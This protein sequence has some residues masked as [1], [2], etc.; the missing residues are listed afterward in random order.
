[1]KIICLAVLSCFCIIFKFS[2]DTA[3]AS[4][5]HIYYLKYRLSFI[6]NMFQLKEDIEA[7]T[8]DVKSV[9]FLSV[10]KEYYMASCSRDGFVKLW[11]LH[12]A[13]QAVLLSQHDEHGCFVNSV[14]LRSHAD[15]G[16]DSIIVSSGG[17][18]GIIYQWDNLSHKLC[19]TL[20]GHTGNVCYLENL[21]GSVQLASCSWDKTARIWR[22]LENVQ[23]IEG[24]NEAIWCCCQVSENSFLTGIQATGIKFLSLITD[25]T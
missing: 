21:Y 18:D 7:H 1:M 4:I 11:K 17:T 2:D 16:L 14:S 13:S 6:I 12:A 20:I 23:T 9:K 24:H 3:E 8:S 15:N 10:G 25:Y 22:D 19:G 5:E